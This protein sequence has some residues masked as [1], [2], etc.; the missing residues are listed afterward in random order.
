MLRIKNEGRWIE[1]VV[2]AMLPVCGEIIVLDDHSTDDTREICRRAGCIVIESPFSDLDEARDKD[3]LLNKGWEY[4]AQPGADYVLMLDGDEELMKEDQP[5][6]AALA[7]E[8]RLLCGMLKVLY[9]WDTEQQIRIDRWY[10]DVWRAS[11]FKLVSPGMTF[12]RTEWNGNLHCSSAPGE[13]I[14]SRERV[15]ARLLHYGYMLRE[16]RV[17]KFHW[18]NSIDPH[19]EFEDQYRHMVIGDLFPPE[20]SFKWA[21]PL[22][23]VSL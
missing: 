21:G 11:I 20:S 16:D 10:R 4:G 1:R 8:G 5:L 23:V 6:L 17:R 3:F 19:N 18:Y 2:K 12:L 15:A 9:L 7:E 13:V 22:Q 14:D